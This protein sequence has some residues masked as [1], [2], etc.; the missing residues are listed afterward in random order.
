MAANTFS[1][2]RNRANIWWIPDEIFRVTSARC[3]VEKPVFRKNKPPPSAR[4]RRIYLWVRNP[5]GFERTLCLLHS[6]RTTETKAVWRHYDPYIRRKSVTQILVVIFQKAWI[7]HQSSP[8]S[9]PQVFSMCVEVKHNT[10]STVISFTVPI[11]LQACA[12]ATWVIIWRL[13]TATDIGG[14]CNIARKILCFSERK[15]LV[16]TGLQ[17]DIVQGHAFVNIW[18]KEE[19]SGPYEQA[20]TV[21]GRPELLNQF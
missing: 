13:R 2:A 1:V 7:K 10:T 11:V 19:I 21:Q 3:R 20:S 6:S 5:W 4:R 14:R 16:R 17:H 15:T 18:Q 8:L 12:C 9:K